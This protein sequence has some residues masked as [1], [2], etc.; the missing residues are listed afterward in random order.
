MRLDPALAASDDRGDHPLFEFFEVGTLVNQLAVSV[1]IAAVSGRL[2]LV[3]QR[4]LRKRHQAAF[5]H[6]V[7]GFHS[8]IIAE[9]AVKMR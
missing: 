5:A 1:A 7:V 8:C 3:A 9:Q 4:I 6:R 2:A